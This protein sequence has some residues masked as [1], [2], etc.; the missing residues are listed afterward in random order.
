MHSKAMTD[1]LDPAQKARPP[2]APCGAN[3]TNRLKR[4]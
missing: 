4:V 3:D 2:G 1:G